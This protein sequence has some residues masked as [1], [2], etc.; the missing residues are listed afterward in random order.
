MPDCTDK[1]N[2]QILFNSHITKAGRAPPHLKLFD[3]ISAVKA[4]PVVERSKAWVCDLS[5]FSDC[6]YESRP[7]TWKPVVSDVCCQVEVSAKG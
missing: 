1:Y 7:E 6:G 5:R 2:F 4:Q 3:L